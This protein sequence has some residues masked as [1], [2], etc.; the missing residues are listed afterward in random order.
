MLC[1]GGARS[2]VGAGIEQA[3]FVCNHAAWYVT[4]VLV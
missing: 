1:S 2:G 3:I 4:D